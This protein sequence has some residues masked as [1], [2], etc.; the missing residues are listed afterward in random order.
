MQ[1]LCHGPALG[2]PAAALCP[3]TRS[4]SFSLQHMSSVRPKC[5]GNLSGMSM[6]AVVPCMHA[7]TPQHGILTL[8]HNAAQRC[9][10]SHCISDAYPVLSRSA[11]KPALQCESMPAGSHVRH[12]G[13]A[14]T[15]Q[16][17][18]QAPVQQPWRLE[19]DAAAKLRLLEWGG[20]ARASASWQ[21]RWVYLYRGRVYVLESKSAPQE[22][23]S[24]NIWLKRCLPVD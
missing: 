13:G 5:G 23:T 15:G 22:L 18:A 12:A 6:A 2:M 21:K 17:A 14:Q 19:P 10:P 4:G 20:L 11:R 7:R 24:H 16:A 1:G 9:H 8:L 3:S